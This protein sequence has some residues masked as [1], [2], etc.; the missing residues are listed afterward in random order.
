MK[1]LLMCFS[2]DVFRLLSA[3]EVLFEGWNKS[4]S[5]NC[6]EGQKKIKRNDNVKSC[7]MSKCTTFVCNVKLQ[8]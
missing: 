5:F 6:E 1:W 8:I 2:V 7:V 3:K 4:C